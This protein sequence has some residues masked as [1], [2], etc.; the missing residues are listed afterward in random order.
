MRVILLLGTRLRRLKID[1][2]PGDIA[3]EGIPV[4][5]DVRRSRQFHIHCIVCQADAVISGFGILR[6]LV[7]CAS[8]IRTGLPGER[9]HHQVSEVR[10]ARPVEMVLPEPPDPVIIM[11]VA[12]AVLPAEIA[13][14]RARLHKTER[15]GR[16]GKGMPGIGRSY[17]RVGIYRQILHS[18]A[19]YRQDSKTCQRK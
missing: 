6:L 11:I 19:G 15:I 8:E 13:G 2:H 3:I 7:P 16:P 10:N 9:H 17:H 1:E 18:V 14:M 4:H 12:A 5:R